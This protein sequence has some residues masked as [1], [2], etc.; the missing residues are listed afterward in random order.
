ME[1]I[2]TIKQLEIQRNTLENTAESIAEYKESL[3]ISENFYLPEY[4]KSNSSGAVGGIITAVI[5]FVV[6]LIIGAFVN[7][8]VGKFLPSASTVF[9]II[10]LIIAIITAI[11][12]VKSMIE[13]NENDRINKERY[14]RE[15]A[16]YRRQI[17]EDKIRVEQE[18]EII[19]YCTEIEEQI[20]DVYNDTVD[21]L[22]QMYANGG[23]YEK[24]QFDLTAICMFSEYLESKRCKV[25][26]GHEGAYNLYEYEKRV[27]LILYK[28]DEIIEQ[29][30]EIKQSQYMIYNALT[31]IQKQQ[32]RM[33]DSINTMV[34]NQYDIIENQKEQSRHLEEIEYNTYVLKHNDNIRMIYNLN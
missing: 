7:G 34:Q 6:S 16:E 8:L 10:G 19:D 12:S 27:G 3:G 15:Y 17:A 21:V 20:V 14:D 29:L 1:Y 32:E 31:E 11:S 13:E 26:V 9:V 33:I 2:N 24:Y 28:L 22:E 5:V 18:L 23:L 25:L 30:E 4:E